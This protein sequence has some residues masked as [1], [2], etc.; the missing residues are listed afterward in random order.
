MNR[1][2][3]IWL[4]LPINISTSFKYSLVIKGSNDLFVP[5]IEHLVKSIRDTK[6]RLK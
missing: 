3:D 4:P 6:I 1:V 5:N 2:Y